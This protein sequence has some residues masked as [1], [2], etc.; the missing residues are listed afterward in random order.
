MDMV[1]LQNEIHGIH[2]GSDSVRGVSVRGDL[3]AIWNNISWT[4]SPEPQSD[5][6]RLLIAFYR[7]N[8]ADTTFAR[9]CAGVVGD[10]FDEYAGVGFPTDGDAVVA[11]GR[12]GEI[13]IVEPASDGLDGVS[14]Q[15][16]YS[17]HVKNTRFPFTEGIREFSDG[18]LY[19]VD[20]PQDAVGK[21]FFV[22]LVRMSPTSATSQQDSDMDPVHMDYTAPVQEET[23]E[24]PELTETQSPEPT[25]AP[26]PTE[27]QSPEPTKPPN[28]G[29]TES[30]TPGSV[31]S[32]KSLP[33]SILGI[34]ALL[35]LI[36]AIF[37]F[38][39]HPMQ[40]PQLPH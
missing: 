21:K 2:L 24:T 23:T 37:H 33:L 35:A 38:I 31:A 34:G 8:E 3:I 36:A 30:E 14:D 16:G 1:D 26:E 17:R 9:L 20:R 39:T 18:S 32:P 5:Q 29:P 12:S 11:S 22:G 40:I 25:E 10:K 4:E 13:A 15:I 19:I 27:I 7:Y 6:A 28:P